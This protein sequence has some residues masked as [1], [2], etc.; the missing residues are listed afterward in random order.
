MSNSCQ[1]TASIRSQFDVITSPLKH[2][3]NANKPK[4]TRSILL[5]VRVVQSDQ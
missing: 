1:G 5:L 3:C 2:A 4:P